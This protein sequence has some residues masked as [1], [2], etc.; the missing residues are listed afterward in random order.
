MNDFRQNVQP[1]SLAEPEFTKL[2]KFIVNDFG[3]KMPPNKK[4]FL[5]GRLQKRLKEL[6]FNSFEEYVKYLFSSKGQQLEVAFLIDAV[7]TNKTEFFREQ[8]HFRFLLDSGIQNYTKW[9][10]KQKISIWSAGCSSGEE[11]YSIAM[12]MNELKNCQPVSYRILA[13]DVAFSKLE[14]AVKGIYSEDRLREVP[15][16]YKHKYMLK[17]KNQ[18]AG[19]IKIASDVQDKIEFRK[20]NL[21]SNDFQSLGKFDLIFCRN[22]LIYFDRELQYRILKKFCAVLS[23]G[24]YLF[25]GHSESI[26]GLNLPLKSLRP[27]IFVRMDD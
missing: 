9:T 10:R 26:A 27:T 17:G 8:A 1:I 12:T 13:T 11:A 16:D 19:K 23:K 2:S 21:L 4:I 18:Y 15:P 5:Q 20:F 22:V 7:S 14:Q 24:G 25:L 3:I 6:R